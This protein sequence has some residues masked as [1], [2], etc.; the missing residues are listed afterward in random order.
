[1]IIPMLD[2]VTAINEVDLRARNE[3]KVIGVTYRPE[4]ASRMRPHWCHHPT[5]TKKERCGGKGRSGQCGLIALRIAGLDLIC[6]DLVKRHRL[7][8][9]RVDLP[10]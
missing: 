4:P 6:V 3:G 5:T 10:A 9:I 8:P 1:M 2:L 7:Y